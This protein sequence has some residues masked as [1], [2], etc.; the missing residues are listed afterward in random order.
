MM[1]TGSQNRQNRNNNGMRMESRPLI[2]PQPSQPVMPD[3]KLL[4]RERAAKEAAAKVQQKQNAQQSSL[5]KNRSTEKRRGCGKGTSGE[6]SME[7]PQEPSRR[8]TA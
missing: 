4:S 2:K 5:R 1:E 3:E 7:R 8:A 6:Q